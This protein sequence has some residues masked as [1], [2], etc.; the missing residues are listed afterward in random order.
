VHH[1]PLER[2]E[3]CTL[4]Q[5]MQTLQLIFGLRLLTAAD[6]CA[7][8]AEFCSGSFQLLAMLSPQPVGDLLV[9]TKIGPNCSAYTVCGYSG[10]IQPHLFPPMQC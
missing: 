10:R 7:S 6:I 1:A 8:A 3:D 5:H 9:C 2:I 4:H